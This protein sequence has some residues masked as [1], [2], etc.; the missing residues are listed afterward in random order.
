VFDEETLHK[1]AARP[2]VDRANA[3]PALLVKLGA[4]GRDVDGRPV[5]YSVAY[6]AFEL[7]NAYR[8]Y[9]RISEPT[10][11]IDYPIV[12]VVATFVVA[13]A[14]ISDVTPHHGGLVELHLSGPTDAMA[15]TFQYRRIKTKAG[16]AIEF[17][18]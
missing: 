6:D 10:Q 3:I 15:D 16:G 11:W 12:A 4:A 14:K 13:T 17:I 18:N 5:G 9:W 8:M 1:L 7:E 2:F